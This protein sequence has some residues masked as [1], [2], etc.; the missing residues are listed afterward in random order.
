M[1]RVTTSALLGLIAFTLACGS[2]GGTLPSAG[3]A[4][5]QLRLSQ[6]AS[7]PVTLA[8]SGAVQR[9]GTS[10]VDAPPSAAVVRGNVSSLLVTIVRVDAL[11][12]GAN[13]DEDASWV[14]MPVV[15]AITVD[16][17]DLPLALEAARELP[18]GTIEP[19]AYR[20]LRLVISDASITFTT[21]VQVGQRTWAAGTPHPLR[22][23]GP[24]DTRIKIPTASFTLAD[25]EDAQIDLVLD[26]GASVQTI[27][28]TPNFILMSPVITASRRR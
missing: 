15:P 17:L 9:G 19:G 6:S 11:R 2:D 14:R 26:P 4:S 22:I 23:P 7:L 8:N 28:A 3:G 20:N 13:E 25:A 24:S 1:S 12:L 5:L 27:T 10:A 21:P 18:P 16:L